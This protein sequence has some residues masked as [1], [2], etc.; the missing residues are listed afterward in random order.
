MVCLR[1]IIVNT[2]NKG[3]DKDVIIIII[4]IIITVVFMQA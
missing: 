4:I 1:C 2:L 3:G